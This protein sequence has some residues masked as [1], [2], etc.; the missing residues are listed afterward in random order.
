MRLSILQPKPLLASLA[1]CLLAAWAT[2]AQSAAISWRAQEV[3]G[4]GFSQVQIYDANR[5]GQFAGAAVRSDGTRVAVTGDWNSPLRLTPMGTN[6]VSASR[7]NDRGDLVVTRPM[8]GFTQHMAVVAADG[9]VRGQTTVGQ[10]RNSSYLHL[11]ERGDAAGHSQDLL[12]G[13]S[14][15][16]VQADGTLQRL[17]LPGSLG[18]LGLALNEV[19]DVLT[20]NNMGP[21]AIAQLGLWQQG[22]VTTISPWLGRSITGRDVNDAGRVIGRTSV[23]LPNVMQAFVWDQGQMQLLN[24]ATNQQSLA[25]GLNNAGDVVGMARNSDLIDLGFVYRAGQLIPISLGGAST[26]ATLVNEAGVVAGQGS[27]EGGRNE[28]F[29]YRDG[30]LRRAGTLGGLWSAELAL[31][32]DGLLLGRSQLADFASVDYFV[33]DGERI[34]SIDAMVSGLGFSNVTAAFFGR[35]GSI[36]GNGQLSNGR[37]GAFVLQRDA[38]AVPTPGA[39]PLALVALGACAWVRRRSARH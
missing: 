39:L 4:A 33:F 12:T 16:L 5:H 22:Q 25:L 11:N 19:G 35:D 6:A 9:S 37:V 27:V 23:G 36:F 7:I 38:A 13:Q 28:A 10:D 17:R 21:T 1:V 32:D 14:A 15:V 18:S 3:T 24:F 34:R 20:S 2:P 30:V 26:T 31:S 29:T 8:V